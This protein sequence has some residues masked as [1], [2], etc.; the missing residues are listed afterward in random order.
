M[1]L[2]LVE[3]L[4]GRTDEQLRTFTRAVTDAA[5]NHLDTT[6]DTVQVRFAEYEPDRMAR[7]GILASDRARSDP[8]R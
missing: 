4:T 5:V 3:L 1:P 7:G 6:A 8:G 2:I